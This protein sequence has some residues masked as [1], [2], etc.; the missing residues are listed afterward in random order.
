MSKGSARKSHFGH[1]FIDAIRCWGPISLALIISVMMP[2]NT[3]AQSQPASAYDTLDI[4]LRAEQLNQRCQILNYFEAREIE[5]G[6]NFNK[7]LT[8]EGNVRLNAVETAQ[9]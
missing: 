1:R 2:I 7:N 4:W 9:P 6:I 8:P 3:M 5:R